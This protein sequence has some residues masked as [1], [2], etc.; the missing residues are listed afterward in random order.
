M[1][2]CGIEYFGHLPRVVQIISGRCR[3][4]A[5]LISGPILLI[6]LLNYSILIFIHS[7]LALLKVPQHTMDSLTQVNLSSYCCSDLPFAIYSVNIS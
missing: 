5:G 3:A 2:Y 4:Q 7:N 1:R 6:T